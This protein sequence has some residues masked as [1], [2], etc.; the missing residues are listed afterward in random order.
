MLIVV[1]F[2]FLEKNYQNFWS[3]ILI[4]ERRVRFESVLFAGGVWFCWLAGSNQNY[5]KRLMFEAECLCFGDNPYSNGRQSRKTFS[6][7]GKSL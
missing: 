3:F 1:E 7:S 2:C 5:V 6:E 4:E